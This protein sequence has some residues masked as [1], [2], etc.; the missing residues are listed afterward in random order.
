MDTAV[1]TGLRPRRTHRT[2]T[3]ACPSGSCS[4]S[5]QMVSVS[6]RCMRVICMLNVS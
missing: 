1:W 2:G 3:R 5:L 6:F 4:P